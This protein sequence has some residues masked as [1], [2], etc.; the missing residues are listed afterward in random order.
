MQVLPLLSDALASVGANLLCAQPRC[1]SVLASTA[2][3]A[4]PELLQLCDETP[5]IELKQ[6]RQLQWTSALPWGNQEST[7]Q[8]Q[9]TRTRLSLLNGELVPL[10]CA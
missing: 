3:S 2:N 10:P 7:P 8:L 1:H 6:G 4:T 5:Q 9:E